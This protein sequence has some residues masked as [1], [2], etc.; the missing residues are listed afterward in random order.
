[1]TPGETCDLAIVGGGPAGLAAALVASEFGLDVRLLDEQPRLGGQIYR[2]PPVGFRVDAWLAGRVYRSG[3][4]LLERVER[5]AT[6]R[7]VAEATVWGLFPPEPAAGDAGHRLLFEQAGRAGELHARQVLLATGCYEMPVPF[8]GWQRPGVM[9]AGGI[10]TLLKSQRIAAGARVVLAG[11]HPLLLV[12]ADQ[13]LEAGVH[14]AAVVFSQSARAVVRLL[15]APAPLVGAFPQLLHAAHCLRR[16]RRARVPLM[17]GRVVAEALGSDA[18]EAVRV[19]RSDFRGDSQR[20]ACDTLGLCYGFLASSELA[21]QAGARSAW[22]SGSGWV[23]TSDEFMR[24]SVPHLSVAGELAGVAGAQAA[25]LSGEIAAL[26]IAAD[27]GRIAAG[28]ASARA[29]APRRRLRRLRRFAAVLAQLA[30]PPPRLLAGLAT[31]DTLLCR[32]E[33]VTVGALLDALRTESTVES[34]SSAKLLTRVGMG[35]CQGRMCEL[36]VRRLIGAYR[37][38]P[39]EAIRGYEPRPPVKP[40]RLAALAERAPDLSPGPGGRVA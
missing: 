15:A 7:P 30:D 17:T 40:I 2:Q 34:A 37:G 21:R 24:T 6:L 23:V 4:A 29:A 22:E 20:I 19:C 25:A 27:A 18:V 14:V 3:R 16:I 5:L 11:S 39:L 12:A 32:C 33:D 35:L 36:A 26:G 13:L 9:S 1:M 28:D 31:P 10:Q 38:R 8:P